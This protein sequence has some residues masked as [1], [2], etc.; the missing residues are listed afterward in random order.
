MKFLSTRSVLYYAL[1]FIAIASSSC[2]NSSEKNNSKDQL[3]L[4]RKEL[5]LK[6]RELNLKEKEMNQKKDDISAR[7]PAVKGNQKA[8]N[9]FYIINVAA[10]KTEKEAKLRVRQLQNEGY[11]ADYLWIPD[12]ASLSG[13]N[14]FSVYIGPFDSQYECEVATEDYR[15]M[16][17]SAYGLLVSQQDKR[18]QINGI[19]K[20]TISNAVK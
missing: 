13:A 10:T 11:Q 12:Y 17:P 4:Q 8:E 9:G 2:N 3:D 14:Y 6:E 7:K 19:G 16:Q 20:V 5:E 15:K 1:V 18:V